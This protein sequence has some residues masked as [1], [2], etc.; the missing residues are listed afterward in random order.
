MKTAV[1][2]LLAALSLFSALADGEIAASVT[3][4]DS[5]VI[6]GTVAE[7]T[8]LEGGVVFAD[9]VKIPLPLV[10]ELAADGTNGAQIV[11]LANGDVF[12]LA[13]KTK[14]LSVSTVLGDLTIPLA[15]IRK[16]VFSAAESASSGN[17]IFHCTFDSPEAVLKPAVGPAGTVLMP[18]VFEPGKFGNAMRVNPRSES[19]RFVIPA[20]FLKA[21][22]CIEW[23]GKIQN[24]SDGF[25]SCDPRF[26]RIRFT[27]TVDSVFEFSSNDGVG[28]GGLVIRFPGLHYLQKRGFRCASRYSQ[29]F[30]AEGAQDWHH[31]ALV[32][33]ADGIETPD[34]QSLFRLAVYID[35][36]RIHVE[37]FDWRQKINVGILEST[38]A[39]IDFPFN[40]DHDNPLIGNA[41]Y[42]ID[43]LKI[44]NGD[45][46]SVKR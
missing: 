15:N 41:E 43:E 18:N 45:N 34:S 46:I 14:S 20:G 38:S 23:W 1:F 31:Y 21:K 4:R 19:A 16:V 36:K 44:W 29:Y 8:A 28:G 5:S 3:L 7:A 32:W 6:K 35:G 12:H 9:D 2:S 25:S 30:G 22:G 27:E 11:T 10:R 24:P 17:L 13:P 39:T 33:N 26:F 37:P 42:L 40:S